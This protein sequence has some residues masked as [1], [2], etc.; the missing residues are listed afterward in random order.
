MKRIIILTLTVLMLLTSASGVPAAGAASSATTP[1]TVQG[2]M[3]GDEI[4]V[5]RAEFLQAV[6]RETGLNLDGIYFIRAPEVKD[7]APDVQ[8]PA[9][10]YADELIIAG[11]YGVVETGTPF[12]PDSP[13]LR[14]E[15]ADLAVKA[16]NAK[17]GPIPLTQQ[18]IIFADAD[19]I[20][21][22][23]AGAVQDARKLGLI[24]PDSAHNIRPRHPLNRGE[25][26]ELLAAIEKFTGT[27]ENE[28]GVTWELSADRSR[29]TLY[30]G[31]KPTGGYVITINSAAVE[32]GTLLVYYS[33][34]APGPDDVV[35][36]AITYP[37]AE[38]EL[39][40][41]I[42]PFSSVRAV[43]QDRINRIAFTVGNN[44]YTVG[45]K[46]FRVDFPPF[47]RD[48][49]VF[50]PVRF[51]ASALG[52]PESGIHWSRSA[53]TVTLVKGGVTV[54]LAVG[55]NILYVND[56]PVETDTT[57]VLKDD[58]VFLPAG[59]IARA[60]GYRVEWDGSSQSVILT[61]GYTGNSGF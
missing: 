27:R 26:R 44:N 61:P 48:D 11:H 34:H 52:V 1:A 7:V 37:R 53:R 15:A 5:T 59:H 28:D 23:Y 54:T 21:S 20:S 13:V 17:L 38:M 50:V 29:I 25:C 49:R 6:I 36:Q 60:F 3:S 32:E 46:T 41:G 10:P 22:D 31:E 33:L 42:G 14:E 47:I 19:R 35:T 18:Y 39:P 56:R 43:N 4:A 51:L 40:A 45:N 55:G 2:G 30:W 8:D 57:A 9:A 58:R 12:R 16:L 24:S